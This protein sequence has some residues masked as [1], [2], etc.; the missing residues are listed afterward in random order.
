MNHQDEKFLNKTDKPNS[1]KVL[2]ENIESP[3]GINN[4]NDNNVLISDQITIEHKNIQT[5]SLK[6]NRYSIK[7]S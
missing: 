1:K 6:S 2:S 5:K 3:F 7:E 4:F